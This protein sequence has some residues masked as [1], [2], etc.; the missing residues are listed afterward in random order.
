M[1][2]WIGNIAPETTDEELQA[3]LQKYG[4]PAF[5]VIQ[6]V[7]GDGSRP[8]VMLEFEGADSMALYA[9]AQRL[10]GVYWK[11]RELLIQVIKQ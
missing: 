11:E 7:P 8:A 2:L 3:F 1:R 10:N 5:T 9:V 4:A 6:Q